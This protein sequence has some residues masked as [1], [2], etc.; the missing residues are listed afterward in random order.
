[1]GFGLEAWLVGLGVFFF[2]FYDLQPFLE[3]LSLDIGL[4]QIVLYIEYGKTD[5]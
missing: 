5:K 4:Q 1:M 2:F 3:R